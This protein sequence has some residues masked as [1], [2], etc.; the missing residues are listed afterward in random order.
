MTSGSGIE[1]PTVDMLN[2]GRKHCGHPEQQ[3]EE[4]EQHRLAAEAYEKMPWLKFSDNA[5]EMFWE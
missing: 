2:L 5:A 4:R 1:S 3:P